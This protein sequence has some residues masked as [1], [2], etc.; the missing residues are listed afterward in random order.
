MRSSPRSPRCAALPTKPA[1]RRKE[2]EAL[3]AMPDGLSQRSEEISG[4][5]RV[6]SEI[7][8]QTNLGLNAAIEAARRRTGARRRGGR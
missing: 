6:I 8:D 7:A 2:V 3:S 5:I 1:S 4:I